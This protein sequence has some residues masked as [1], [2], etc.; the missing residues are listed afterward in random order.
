VRSEDL[1]Y[2]EPHKSADLHAW[3]TKVENLLRT[4]FGEQSAHFLHYSKFAYDGDRVHLQRIQDVVPIIGILRGALDDLEKGFLARQ[5]FIVSA[6]LFDDLLAQAEH[7]CNSGY[8]DPAAVL[9]RVVVEDSL[10][11]LA[12][13][14]SLDDTARAASIN[15]EL[16]RA[17]RFT[18][19]QWR[20]VQAWLDVGNSAAHGRFDQY[21]QGDVAKTIEDVKRFL[22]SEYLA[23]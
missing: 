6:A 12:R 8:K 9:V 13:A 4:V 21:T 7:L 2:I 14:A 11:R 18:Q 16:R 1:P 15:E 19:P 20:M 3:V 22:A 17:S 23:P 10:R 5:E